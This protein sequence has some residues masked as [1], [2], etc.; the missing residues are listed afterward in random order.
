VIDDNGQKVYEDPY[1]LA[2]GR[3]KVEAA[4]KQESLIE[5]PLFI[6]YDEL[7]L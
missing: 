7:H 2:G 1:A 4:L 6:D 5:R 3:E